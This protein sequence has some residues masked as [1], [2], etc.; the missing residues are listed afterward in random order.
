MTMPAAKVVVSEHSATLFDD[1][2]IRALIATVEE[3]VDEPVVGQLD[4][5]LDHDNSACDALDFRGWQDCPTAA[6]NAASNASGSSG[7]GIDG[8]RELMDQIEKLLALHGKR[9][10]SHESTL[11]P[12]G[13]T[14]SNASSIPI[15]CKLLE[16]PSVAGFK[17]SELADDVTEAHAKRI[18]G[19]RLDRAGQIGGWLQLL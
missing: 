7:S 14:L 15:G 12:A 19:H 5:Q 18:Q 17:A 8:G 9:F 1:A 10:P 16:S 4:A 2:Q 3:H 13:E 11:C 6:L